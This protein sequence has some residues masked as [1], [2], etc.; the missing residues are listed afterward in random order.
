MWD[1]IAANTEKLAAGVL[2]LG[3]IFAVVWSKVQSMRTD[4]AKTSADVAIAESQREVFDQMKDRLADL[5]LQ[6]GALTTKVDAQQEELRKRE[7][8]LHRMRI[9]ILDLEHALETHG[10]PI[11]PV[12]MP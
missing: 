3:G 1:W 12:R 2:G 4:A 9:R 7:M 8:D 10:V 5:A 6:V 11:P